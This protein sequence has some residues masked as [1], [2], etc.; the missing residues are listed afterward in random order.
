MGLEEYRRKR[1]FKTTPEPAGRRRS[2]KGGPTHIFVVQKHAAS[3][4][5][6]DFRLEIGGVLA[7]WAIPK[8]PSMSTQDRRLAMPTEDHPVEYARFEGII[9]EGHYGAGAVIVWDKGTYEPEGDTP[10]AK[11]LRGGELKFRLAGERL[12]GGFI[13]IRSGKRW[14]LIKRRDEDA[15]SSWNIDR[16]NRSVLSGRTLEEVGGGGPRAKRK[17]AQAPAM[18][19]RS[20]TLGR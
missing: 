14:F 9:P 17:Q 7:S 20:R 19:R 13:L 3:R 15:K 12:R 2:L 5:H 8:G 1:D 4:L 16:F 11:Q 10:A 18:K 6:Y